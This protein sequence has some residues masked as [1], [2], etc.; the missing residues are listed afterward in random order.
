MPRRTPARS[1][2]TPYVTHHEFRR[3][4]AA[5]RRTFD[6]R[7]ALIEDLQKTCTIQ[8]QRIA[9]IQAE[10]DEIRGAWLKVRQRPKR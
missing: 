3:E 8:F 6:E 1:R 10:L 7:K 9:Q 2:A 4:V 5:V